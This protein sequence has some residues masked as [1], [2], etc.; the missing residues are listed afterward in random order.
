MWKNTDGVL[1]YYISGNRFLHHMVRY[2]VGT[3]IEIGKNKF[4]LSKFENLLMSP[5]ESVQIFKA[6]SNGLVL[7]SVEYECY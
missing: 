5:N 2:L 3:M 7:E 1:N 6:P 4:S